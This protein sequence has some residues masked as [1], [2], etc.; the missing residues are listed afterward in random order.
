MPP[1]L[2]PAGLERRYRRARDP[3]ERSRWQVVRLLAQGRGTAEVAAATGYS[4]PWARQ[5]ARRYREGG[6]A[7]LGDRRHAN[8]GAAP[9]LAPA[10]RERLRAALGGPA[11]D[12]GLWTGRKVAAWMAAE[13]GRPVGAQRGW[14]WLRR[15]GFSPQRPRPREARADPAAQAAFKGGGLQAE[16]D[17][18]AAAHPGAAVTVWAEDEHRLGL[19]PVARRVWAPRGERPTAPA[20]RRYEWLYAYG[21]VR[22]RTGRTWWCLLPTVSLA[23]FA[24]A[25]A[26]CARDEGIGPAKRAVL[27][28][29]RAGWHASPRLSVP[30]GLH[31]EPLPPHSPELQPA[32]RL[33]PLAGRAHRQPRPRR[34]G[35]A[36]GRP[37]RAVPGAGG[38]PP[39]RQGPHPLPLVAPRTPP[40]ATVITRSRYEA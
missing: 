38:R 14:E 3:V 16:V 34:P 26:E 7:A 25:L 21:F 32:E 29:D 15:L 27:A 35:R 33:W 2:P 9:L 22:P 18:V 31:L 36:G 6:P 30:E 10:Q 4:V 11:P 17:A 13:L 19:L 1:H 24:L 37:G 20:R 12:G 28:L 39:H 40:E 8:P 5:L 23:A